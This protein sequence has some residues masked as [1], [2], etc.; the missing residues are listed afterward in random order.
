MFVFLFVCLF[1]AKDA[2][3]EMNPTCKFL[4]FPV[5]LKFVGCDDSGHRKMMSQDSRVTSVIS[6]VTLELEPLLWFLLIWLLVMLFLLLL[7]LTIY[8]FIWQRLLSKATYKTSITH[9]SLPWLTFQLL[10]L[11]VIFWSALRSLQV[12]LQSW[13]VEES[14]V[15]S[16]WWVSTRRTS[17]TT[18]VRWGHEQKQSVCFYFVGQIFKLFFLSVQSQASKHWRAA[19]V[20]MLVGSIS[21]CHLFSVTVHCVQSLVWGT[22]LPWQHEWCADWSCDISVSDT[23]TDCV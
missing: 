9:E 22:V 14:F 16:V 15:L 11:L 13:A 20:K 23:W 17:W 19:E 3:L 1:Q 6:D 21:C 10:S 4:P 7:L 5:C 2:I 8:S 12:S 18:T